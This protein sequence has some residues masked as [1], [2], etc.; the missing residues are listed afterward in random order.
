[1]YA[2]RAQKN[3]NKGVIVLNN[4][5]VYYQQLHEFQE[6]DPKA[7]QRF[8]DKQFEEALASYPKGC[9]EEVY[10]YCSICGALLKYGSMSYDEGFHFDSCL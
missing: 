3:N 1:M 9:D 5:S 6:E 7:L 8:L 10:R 2:E 4:P